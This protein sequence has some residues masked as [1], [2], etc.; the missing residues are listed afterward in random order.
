MT[1]WPHSEPS[2][3]TI[4]IHQHNHSR[5]AGSPSDPPILLVEETLD[6][7]AEY[8][9]EVVVEVEEVVEEEVEEEGSLL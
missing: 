4:P 6:S 9:Q 2:N 5:D 3:Q 1:T 8:P 7:Q